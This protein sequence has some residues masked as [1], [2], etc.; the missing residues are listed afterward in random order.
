MV[1]A[2]MVAPVHRMGRDEGDGKDAARCA[3]LLHGRMPDCQSGS[4]R[5]CERLMG[6]GFIQ[7][8]AR[9]RGVTSPPPT[10]THDCLPG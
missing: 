3:A 8:M 9:G 2:A 10:L 1:V 5:G 7:S 6:S 4:G